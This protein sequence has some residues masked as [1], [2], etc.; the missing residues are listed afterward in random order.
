MELHQ[1]AQKVKSKGDLADFVRT[2]REDLSTHPADWE[3]PTLEKFL[4]AMES[5]IRDTEQQPYSDL[6]WKNF[7]ELLYAAT[8][9]G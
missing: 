9:Y 7:A 5:W 1:E 4:N 6:R 2:L 3:N 8:I